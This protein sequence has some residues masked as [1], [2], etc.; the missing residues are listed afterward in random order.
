L[1][2]STRYRF[3]NRNTL[4]PRCVPA[5]STLQKLLRHEEPETRYDAINKLGRFHYDRRILER[6]SLRDSEPL[7]Q[8]LARDWLERRLERT[9]QHD[10]EEG[11]LY[12]HHELGRSELPLAG[13]LPAVVVAVDHENELSPNKNIKHLVGLTPQQMYNLGIERTD[14]TC[15]EDEDGAHLEKEMEHMMQQLPGHIVNPGL[16]KVVLESLKGKVNALVYCTTGKDVIEGPGVRIS[17]ALSKALDVGPG[18]QLLIHSKNGK[19][20]SNGRSIIRV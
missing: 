1:A 2:E 18:E 8:E 12:P 19:L 14:P 5:K 17:K 6:S 15:G 20:P 11:T 16:G 10:L 4:Q 3:A 9:I 7:N 13:K